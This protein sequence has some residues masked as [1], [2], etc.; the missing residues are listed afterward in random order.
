M[1]LNFEFENYILNISY[2]NIT[3]YLNVWS[4]IFWLARI[5]I[6]NQST[7]FRI[8]P[9]FLSSTPDWL[10]E[11][12]KKQIS[13]RANQN[14]STTWALLL[15]G[16]EIYKMLYPVISDS[17]RIIHFPTKMLYHIWHF[18]TFFKYSMAVNTYFIII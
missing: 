9:C 3:G 6:I 15:I 10:D 5:S 8:S 17:L 1:Y 7:P 12:D 11:N 14:S 16:Q 13:P 4:K 18:I 2:I